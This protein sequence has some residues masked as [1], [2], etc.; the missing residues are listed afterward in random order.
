MRHV[1]E[2]DVRSRLVWTCGLAILASCR[3]PAPPRTVAA[4]ETCAPRENAE[5]EVVKQVVE[6]YAGLAADDLTRFRAVVAPGFYAF[7]GG[8][9]YDGDALATLIA[10]AHAAGKRFEWTV[11]QPVVRIDC[12]TALLSYT[13]VGAM[14]DA[15]AMQPRSWLESATLRYTDGIWRLEFFH[16]TRVPPSAP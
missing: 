1:I 5:A 7:D 13:N 6:M 3:H 11:S 8:E 15:T 9:R 14:G 4:S 2:G 10:T 12:T 16:S